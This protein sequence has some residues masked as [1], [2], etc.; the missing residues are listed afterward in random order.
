MSGAC[1]TT[2]LACSFLRCLPLGKKQL[3]RYAAFSTPPTQTTGPPPSRTN[4]M[5]NAC[6]TNRCR[7]LTFRRHTNQ[8]AEGEDLAPYPTPSPEQT[9]PSTWHIQRITVCFEFKTNSLSSPLAFGISQL[10]CSEL[11]ADPG[12]TGSAQRRN[13]G[14]F[15]TSRTYRPTATPY[16]Q[17]R[18]PTDH[19]PVQ[20]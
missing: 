5:P 19:S 2:L 13:H 20:P 15:P 9:K 1:L 4:S 8:N 12:R 18:Y 14:C 7:R 16:Q 10:A 6:S 3:I 17:F 11:A